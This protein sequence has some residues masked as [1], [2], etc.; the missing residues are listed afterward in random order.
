MEHFPNSFGFI[1]Y[2]P[3]KAFGKN[4]QCSWATSLSITNKDTSEI[5]LASCAKSETRRDPWLAALPR[6]VE[7]TNY[8]NQLR[9][10]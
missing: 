7:R 1:E 3:Q 8:R 9:L 2:I 10:N 5:C 6:D 4:L